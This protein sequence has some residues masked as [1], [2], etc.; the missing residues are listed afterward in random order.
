MSMQ[1]VGADRARVQWRTIMDQVAYDGDEV[2]VEQYGK[3]L[4]AIVPFDDFV[5]LQ[6]FVNDLQTARWAEAMLDFEQ[7]QLP[8]TAVHHRALT[9]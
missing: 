9:S 8:A 2:V 7:E 5:A 6:A 3:P 1:T 4:A